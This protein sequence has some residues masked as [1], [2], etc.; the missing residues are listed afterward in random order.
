MPLG[1]EN[2]EAPTFLLTW[3]DVD[4][5]EKPLLSKPQASIQI[6]PRHSELPLAIQML[7][8]PRSSKMTIA[9]RSPTNLDFVQLDAAERPWSPS[10]NL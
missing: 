1:I 5:H 3:Q 6:V 10:H 9:I 8:L 2:M 4:A 7:R